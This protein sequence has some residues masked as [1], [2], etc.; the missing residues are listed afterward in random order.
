MN[1]VMDKLIQKHL[2]N[3]ITEEEKEYLL[4]VALKDINTISHIYR[5]Y[6]LLKGK[7]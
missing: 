6:K 4:D 3:T 7:Y 2:N 5:K 1:H